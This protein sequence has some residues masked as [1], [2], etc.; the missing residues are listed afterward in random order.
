MLS[1]LRVQVPLQAL[2]PLSLSL[3]ATGVSI[4]EKA[5]ELGCP[6]AAPRHV[7]P[8]GPP[9]TSVPWGPHPRS[10]HLASAPRLLKEPILAWS[11]K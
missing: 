9:H 3:G 8:S 4:E 2:P 11:L 1:S 7:G 6:E 10:S 5:E